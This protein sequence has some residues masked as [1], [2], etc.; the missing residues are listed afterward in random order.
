MTTSAHTPYFGPPV[1]LVHGSLHRA[2]A[3]SALLRTI[4]DHLG[5]RA[6]HFTDLESIPPLNPDRFEETIASVALWR[7][8]IEQSGAVL[9]GCPEYAGGVSGVVKNALDWI[10]GSGELYRKP[11]GV[12]TAGTSG[13]QNARRDLAQT[14]V[15]QGAYV[16][17]HL[18]V[19]GPRTKIDDQGLVSDKTTLAELHRLGDA[20]ARSASLPSE[21]L[22]AATETLVAGFGIEPGHVPPP[23]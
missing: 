3:N 6:R 22:A 19:V 7:R 5:D 17:E 18:G 15:W 10:V 9:I 11:V 4:G 12:L 1:L 13:G 8:S 2:S 20:L 23:S 21:E 14:L 16:V